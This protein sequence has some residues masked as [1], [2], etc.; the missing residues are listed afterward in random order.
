VGRTLRRAWVVWAL[1]ER[2]ERRAD[3]EGGGVDPVQGSPVGGVR[4]GDSRRFRRRRG[5]GAE[6]VLREKVV[7][8][9]P[10]EGKYG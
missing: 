6:L 9:H 3:T 5:T 8:A 10:A 1:I 7:T 2:L 4:A